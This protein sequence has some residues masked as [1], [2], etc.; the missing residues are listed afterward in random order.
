MHLRPDRDVSGKRHR[1]LFLVDGENRPDKRLLLSLVR[2]DGE[3]D[4]RGNLLRRFVEVVHGSE[5]RF[6]N[7]IDAM[8]G[9]GFLPDRGNG[10]RKVVG[11]HAGAFERRRDVLDEARS[12]LP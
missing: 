7:R 12:D 4:V 9:V 10:Q 3:A 5:Q 11:A 6:V 2:V 8:R 1:L